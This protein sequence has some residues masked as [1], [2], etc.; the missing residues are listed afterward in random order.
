MTTLSIVLVELSVSG[1]TTGAATICQK[2]VSLTELI[3]TASVVDVLRLLAGIGAERDVEEEEDEDEDEEEEE[4]E[5]ELGGAAEGWED[6][7]GGMEKVVRR[8]DPEVLLALLDLGP[9][10]TATAASVLSLLMSVTRGAAVPVLLMADVVSTAASQ[11]G[12]EVD[13]PGVGP[14]D[15]DEGQQSKQMSLEHAIHNQRSP[16]SW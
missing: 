4:E 14:S 2:S 8:P 6:E 9:S 3:A 12:S 15:E 10:A 7:I 5:E 11:I 1:K 13:G 16:L